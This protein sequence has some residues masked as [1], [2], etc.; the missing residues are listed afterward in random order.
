LL[1]AFVRVKDHPCSA[2]GVGKVIDTKN[3]EATVSWFNSPLTEPIVEQI[4]VHKLVPVIL[5]KQARVY[6]L[7]RD[8]DTW[9]VGRVLDADDQRTEV[10]F[11]NR[12]DLFLPVKDLEVRWDRPID[13]P[14]AFLAA[15]INESPQFAQARTRFARSLIAQRGACSGMSGL[16]SSIID[17]EKHQYE[18]VRRVLQDP[19]QRYLLADEVGLGKTIEAGVLIRQFVLDNPDTHRILVIVPSALVVQWRRELRK[20]FLLGDLLDESLNVI[21][22]DAEPE[23]LVNA[24]QGVG[25]GMVVIDE[26]HHLS[27]DGDLYEQLREWIIA[28]PRL[29]LLSA[30]PVLHNE[31][32]FLEMLHLLDPEVYR[33]DRTEA[34]KQRI[35]HRQALAE[36]VAGLIPENLLLIENFIDDLTERFPDDTLLCQHANSL[37]NIIMEFPDESDPQ[38]IQALTRLRAHITETYRL[39][40]RILRNRRRDLPFLTPDRAGVECVDYSSPETAHLVQAVEAWRGRAAGEVYANEDSQYAHSLAQWFVLLLETTLVD[41][42]K[43]AA[44]VRDRLQDLANSPTGVGWEHEP[45]VELEDIAKQLS[46]DNERLSALITLLGGQLQGGKKVVV[47]CT[48]ASVADIVGETLQRTLSEPVDRHA[49]NDDPEDDYT[50]QGWERFLS[51]STPCVLVCDVEAEEGLNLQGGAKAVVHFDLPLAPNRVEQRLGRA[52]RYGSGDSIRSFA[53]CCTDDPY[54]RAWLTYL[55]K[56][57]RLFNR[58]VASLQYLIE[59][60]MQ[61]LAQALFIEGVDALNELSDRTCGAQGTAERE[62]CRI[63]DQDALDAL[64]LS[65]EE[66]QFDSLTDVDSDWRDMAES[67]RQWMVEILQIEEEAAIT[68]HPTSFGFG[69]FRFCFSYHNRGPNT[70]IPLKRILSALMQLLDLDAGGAHSKLLKTGWYTCRRDTAI[71]S[72]APAEGIRLVRWGETLIERI[73]QITDLD[74]RGRAAAMWRQ[75]SRYQVRSDGPADLYLRFD[76]IVEVDIAKAL[77]EVGDPADSVSKAISRRGDMA[78]APF[79]KTIWV[80]EELSV[81]TNADIL[82]VLEAPYQ[83]AP[84]DG[85]HQDWNI[86]SERWPSVNKLDMSVVKAWRQWIPEARDVAEQLLR[87]ETALEQLCRQAIERSRESDEGR[88]AQLRVRIQHADPDIANET[89]A[90]LASEEL[91]AKSLYAAIREPRITLGTA[92]AVFVSP[93]ALSGLGSPHA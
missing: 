75:H 8:A 27:R 16:I 38:F 25:K 92:L 63:N 30:T 53:L 65:D 59:E 29:F 52:D 60:E 4:A 36:S 57:L 14:S 41:P 1:K 72:S 50:E 7:D 66:S 20:R 80:D 55:D 48:N 15:Q 39:D 70:L 18:V 5:E 84:N 51:A 88:F 9:R 19:I 33:L 40:R 87:K 90:L 10:R 67:V 12:L 37:R 6:W 82:E 47:F 56:G 24:L 23:Q 22:M 46:A 45:L 83:R 89:S 91:I 58:S 28:V 69:A 31:R 64:T 76:F 13:D 79:Y 11:A 85:S 61:D 42:Q 77:P 35:E 44:L 86:N 43:V 74:D 49:L 3:T 2:W 17:L 81:V 71:A 32:G 68:A 78:L 21:A 34:F 54:A 26:A 93:H 73:Q 62:L